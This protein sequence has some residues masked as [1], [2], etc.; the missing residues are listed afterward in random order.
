MPLSPLGSIGERL[1]GLA[2]ALAFLLELLAVDEEP[3][4]SRYFASQRMQLLFECWVE[5]R[6]VAGE[7]MPGVG[8]RYNQGDR[9]RAQRAH[10]VLHRVHSLDPLNASGG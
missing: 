10:N 3:G 4:H 9:E 7:C 6:S 8:D 1:K 5:H 2:R